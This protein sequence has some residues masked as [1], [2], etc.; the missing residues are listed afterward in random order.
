M[1]C[2]GQTDNLRALDISSGVPDCTRVA[3]FPALSDFGTLGGGS[4]VSYLCLGLFVTI[5]VGGSID[6]YQ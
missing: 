2:R 6:G 5:G 4:G 3:L 1:V